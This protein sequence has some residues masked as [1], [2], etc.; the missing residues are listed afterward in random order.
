VVATA[1]NICPGNCETGSHKQRGLCAVASID[2]IDMRQCIK[3][4]NTSRVCPGQ[5]DRGK[6]PSTGALRHIRPENLNPP[7][8]PMTL[9]GSTLA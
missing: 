2:S 7:A 3:T 8:K 1:P 9:L 6:E 4:F 5:L